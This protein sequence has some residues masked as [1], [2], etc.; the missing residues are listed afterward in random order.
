MK[1]REIYIGQEIDQSPS[2]F[3]PYAERFDIYKEK[4]ELFV[5]GTND[6]YNLG[7]GSQSGRALPEVLDE[8]KHF[9]G[10][11]GGSSICQVNY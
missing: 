10:Y 7:T 11:Q 3:P 1:D 4:S 6:N 2:K 5:W 9:K 8:G